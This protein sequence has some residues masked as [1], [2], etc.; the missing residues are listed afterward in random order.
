MS[1]SCFCLTRKLVL[2]YHRLPA[3]FAEAHS[4]VSASLQDTFEVYRALMPVLYANQIRDVPSIAMQMANDHAHL[5]KA[6]QT[7][8]AVSATG[9][10]GQEQAKKLRAAGDAIFELQ[11]Q[12]Q[13]SALMDILDGAQ[14]FRAA[15]TDAGFERIRQAINGVLHNIESL[16]RVLKVCVPA[17][18]ATID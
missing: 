3:S 16:A 12:V 2:I 6:I 18:G 8:D 13:R 14:A 10:D 9:W 5:A 1:F 15:G 11:L 4:I 17:L 7:S